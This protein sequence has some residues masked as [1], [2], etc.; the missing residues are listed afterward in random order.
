MQ[1]HASD[2]GA[3]G[4]QVNRRPRAQAL[5]VQHEVLGPDAALLRQPPARRVIS[6]GLLLGCACTRM[7]TLLAGLAGFACM[8]SAMAIHA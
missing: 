8:E 5:P 3:A 6:G 4:G 1:D 2:L 7:P